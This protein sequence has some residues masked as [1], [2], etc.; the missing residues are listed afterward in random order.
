MIEIDG[1]SG[2]RHYRDEAHLKYEVI[3]PV[4]LGQ[5]TAGNRAQELQLHEKT[6]A[7]YLRSFRNDGYAGLLDQ[8]H[9]SSGRKERFKMRRVYKRGVGN[10]LGHIYKF[11][12]L[13]HILAN[14]TG[15]YEV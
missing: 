12:N 13:I 4:L 9:S 6:L 5:I 8:R 14:V 15:T 1:I 2:F 10:I 3:R 7:K 11:M